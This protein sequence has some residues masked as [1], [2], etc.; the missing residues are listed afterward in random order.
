MALFEISAQENAGMSIWL[1]S[2]KQELKS[3]IHTKSSLY[4]FDFT[5]D[6]PSVKSKRFEW[7]LDSKFYFEERE[8]STQPSISRH[9]E[10]LNEI[11]SNLDTLVN[12]PDLELEN[13]SL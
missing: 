8:L 4:D 5:Q 3:N 7:D 1:S 11:F 6:L 9:T 2:V 12:I 10:D 13:A